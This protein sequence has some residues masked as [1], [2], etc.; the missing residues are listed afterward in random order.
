M[1]LLLSLGTISV[2]IAVIFQALTIRG[3]IRT[4]R[5]ICRE[6]AAINWRMDLVP[7]RVCGCTEYHPCTDG[8]G[9]RCHWVEWDLCSACARV[10]EG[11]E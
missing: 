4:N 9:C 6:L 8:D 11:L 10:E 5:A 7:C 3:L 1:T 2:S